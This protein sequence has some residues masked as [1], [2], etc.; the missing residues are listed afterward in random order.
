MTRPRRPSPWQRLRYAVGRPLPP[1]LRDWVERDLN[2]RGAFARHLVR[3]QLLFSPIYV[4]F[5]LFPGELYIRVLM[6][7]LA[8]ILGLTYNVIYQPQN[9]ERRLEQNGLP[10]DLVP[11]QTRRR[12]EAERSRYEST[13]RTPEQPDA[14]RPPGSERD[15]GAGRDVARHEHQQDDEGPAQGRR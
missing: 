11:E 1:E 9:R 10:T 12:R 3:N 4:V 13:Y 15:D 5:L 7:L 14:V 2:G 6:V 8:A